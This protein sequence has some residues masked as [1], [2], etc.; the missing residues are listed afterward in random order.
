MSDFE[1]ETYHDKIN[2]V[3][4]ENMYKHMASR[5]YGF[6]FCCDT[7]SA[8]V[9]F[10]RDLIKKELSD[11]NTL[12]DPGADSTIVP[13]AN[14]AQI[15]VLGAGREGGTVT[16][17]P[18]GETESVTTDNFSPFLGE[19]GLAPMVICYDS[20]IGYTTSEGANLV[21]SQDT[22]GGCED[23]VATCAEYTFEFSTA[24]DCS[25]LIGAVDA[26]DCW[27]NTFHISPFA[28][29]AGQPYIYGPYCLDSSTVTTI[30]DM[31]ILTGPNPCTL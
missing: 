12:A 22:I 1:Q 13:P 25:S 9:I 8:K 27:G 28:S 26:L 10:R 18:C 20:D 16:Y 5:R 7:G 15:A 11:L 21:I 2:C 3:F 6:K 14:C 30:G 31:S 19:P 24:M 17:T 4:A 29:C 23:P